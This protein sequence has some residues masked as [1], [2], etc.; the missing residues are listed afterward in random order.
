MTIESII[1]AR[2]IS[3]VMHFTTNSGALGVLATRALKSRARLNVDEQLR[4][5]FQ[6]NA[7]S[8]NKDIAWIDYVNVSISRI[9]TKFFATSAHSWHRSRDF[10][11]CILSFDPIIMTHDGVL[12][13]TTNNMYTGVRRVAGA[14]GLEGLFAP[15]IVQWDRSVVLRPGELPSYLTTCEQA[16]FLYP[17]E[18]ST[19]YLRKI[20]VQCSEDE[21]ELAAQV[22]VV[23]HQPVEIEVKPEL[24]RGVP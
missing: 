6:P 16:E 2:G 18:I 1:A 14:E 5:I 13:A 7:Q 11:W 23:G 22:H 17:Q 4:H 20:Y 19:Q 24:F 8:R 3:S 9:N 15:R 12:F 21:D 10:W